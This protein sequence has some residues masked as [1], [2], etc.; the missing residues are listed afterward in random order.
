MKLLLKKLSENWRRDLILILLIFILAIFLRIYN[1]NHLP[2]FADEA[3]YVRWAQ[4]MKAEPTL[5]FLPLSDGKQPLFMWVLML[6]LTYFDD[7]LIA[8]RILSAL[9]GLAT[10]A[11]IGVMA[12]LILRSMR[13]ALLSMFIFAILPFAIFFDRMALT[14]S[15]LSMF[16]VWT[17]ILV[18]LAV[19]KRRWDLS[20]LTGFSLGGAL[21]TKSP[22]L[23]FSLLIPLTTILGNWKKSE[24][25]FRLSLRYLFYFATIYLI[26]YG[27]Y[28]I[29][30]LGPNYHLLGQRNLDYVYPLS[31]I[32]TKPF[33]PLISHLRGILDYFIKMGSIPLITL[34]V[35]G[36]IIGAK[37]SGKET[38]LLLLWAFLPIIINSEYAKVVTARYV[39]FSLPYICV[40]AGS[41]LLAK[42][43]FKK[44]VMVLVILFGLASIIFDKV[45]LKNVY[46]A[47]LPQGDRSGYLEEWTAGV[48]I[49][50]ISE[51]LLRHKNQNP[52]IN[53]VVGTE[54]YFGTLPDGLQI[55]LNQI[56]KMT[57]IGVGLG[58]DTIPESLIQ[59]KEAGND[60]FLV[61]NSSRFLLKNDEQQK[62][63]LIKSF[64]KG[65][66]KVGSREYKLYGP[67]DLLLFYQLK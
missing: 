40:L 50:E 43:Y 8:G 13:A 34:V 19:T 4:V 17:F 5:R 67:R 6:L 7:P 9:C 12:Y 36:I 15:M 31:H 58:F 53:I 44:A 21:L 23:Y 30:R 60:T 49:K 20:I 65:E 10:L 51:Y 42:G 3:I 62:L 27:M 56:E 35:I 45:L 14:D 24:N 52:N 41:G 28:N 33:D 64:P 57:V 59:S 38:V 32:L 46:A 11:G 37:R 48:G 22:A 18:F 63:E 29:L 26:G 55:Y 16:G 66:R 2:I 39:F 61:I 47:N 1:L 54:G 25:K